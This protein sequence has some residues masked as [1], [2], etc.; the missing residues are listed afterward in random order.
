MGKLIG[1][2]LILGG[3]AGMLASWRCAQKKRQAQA[4]ELIRLFAQWEYSLERERLRL[5]E[6]LEGYPCS[7]PQIHAFLGEFLSELRSK[8]Y[9]SGAKMWRQ[10]LKRNRSRLNLDRDIW[11]LLWSADGAFFGTSSR[12]S[13]RSAAACRNRMEECL[14]RQQTEFLKRQKVYMP[15]GMLAAVLLIILLI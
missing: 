3:C 13:L 10:L 1:I 9:P 5:Y 8:E 15:V 7:Q 2:S 6:F 11:E 12:E 4:V 14:K